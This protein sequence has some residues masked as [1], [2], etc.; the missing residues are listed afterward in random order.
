MRRKRLRGLSI[1]S[2]CDGLGEEASDGMIFFTFFKFKGL[3]E[4]KN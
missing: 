4:C 3:F 1:V 2:S